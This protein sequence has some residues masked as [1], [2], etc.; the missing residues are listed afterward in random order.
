MTIDSMTKFYA[1]IG[2]E[3]DKAGSWEQFM[4]DVDLDSN[5]F[6]SKDEMKAVMLRSEE[7]YNEQ[8]FNQFWKAL[9]TVTKGKINGV[10]NK[11]NLFGGELAKLELL[12]EKALIA[13]K[14]LD[15]YDSSDIPSQI[16]SVVSIEKIKTSVMNSLNINALATM[17]EEQ[18]ESH[19][20]N[21]FNQCCL[22]AFMDEA[23]KYI[24]EEFKDQL[25]EDYDIDADNDLWTLVSN[26]LSHTDAGIDAILDDVA[27]IICN[28]L[29][30]AGIGNAPNMEGLGDYTGPAS[31]ATKDFSTL[32]KAQLEAKFTNALNI[33]NLLTFSIPDQYKT[34]LQDLIDGFIKGVLNGDLALDGHSYRTFEYIMNKDDAWIISNFKGS[35]D[36]K[37][38]AVTFTFFDY[39]NLDSSGNG[40]T[41][42]GHWVSKGMMFKSWFGVNA[43]PSEQQ[44]ECIRYIMESKT[45]QN[46]VAAAYKKYQSGEITSEADLYTEIGK[47]VMMNLAQ[48]MSDVGQK[49]EIV[50]QMLFNSFDVAKKGLTYWSGGAQPLGVEFTTDELRT[51]YNQYIDLLKSWKNQLSDSGQ[52]EKLQKIISELESDSY[53]GRFLQNIQT[54]H[55]MIETLNLESELPFEAAY[56]VTSWGLSD[57]PFEVCKGME[58]DQIGTITPVWKDPNNEPALADRTYT[59]T[60]SNGIEVKI[61]QSGKITVTVPSNV[62]VEQVRV[63]FALLV[64]GEEVGNG[65]FLL[66]IAQTAGEGGDAKG[67]LQRASGLGTIFTAYNGVWPDSNQGD[68]EHTNWTGAKSGAITRFKSDFSQKLVDNAEVAGLDKSKAQKAANK[69]NAYFSA[70]LNTLNN[71]LAPAGSNGMTTTYGYDGLQGGATESY[72]SDGY[73][74]DNIPKSYCYRTR[75]YDYGTWETSGF[76]GKESDSGVFILADIDGKDSFDIYINTSQLLDKFFDF[77]NAS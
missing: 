40:T 22:D 68:A 42:N 19:I 57:S 11:N 75:N 28:Y 21:L 45:Y 66:N 53:P 65:E 27:R 59:T 26:Y 63:E 48:I 77:Y 1:F 56:S 71:V 51:L 46:I 4:G 33:N 67:K 13:Q 61:S 64:K 60:C 37:K 70:I 39:E 41:I 14:C 20:D 7:G 9:D 10:K 55:N 36:Y 16:S 73:T 18:I 17:T 32:Q 15:E 47:Q 69:L 44:T 30:Q 3:I 35:E 2:K 54:A 29:A 43:L 8:L 12:S 34:Q 76:E 49:C 31:T 25:P 74:F 72:D 24:K 62:D 52:K 50:E 58:G 6:I 23:T 38:L 5:N